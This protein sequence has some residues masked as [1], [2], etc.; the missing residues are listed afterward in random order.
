MTAMVTPLYS[1]G[2]RILNQF[3]ALTRSPFRFGRAVFL[4]VF[5]NF[6]EGFEQNG[7]RRFREHYE[8]IR[9][10]VPKQ[11]LLEYRVSEGW[12]PLCEFLGDAFPSGEFPKGNS[13]ADLNERIQAYLRDEWKRIRGLGLRF[14]ALVAFAIAVRM[15]IVIARGR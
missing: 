10:T 11:R 13:K 6:Y 8:F 9:R 3:Q 4:Y 1:A 12:G 7:R 5:E 14:A 2:P 15:L